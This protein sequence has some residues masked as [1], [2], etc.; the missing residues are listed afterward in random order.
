MLKVENEL[1]KDGD[2]APKE[3]FG[4]IIIVNDLMLKLNAK[5]NIYNN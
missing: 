3:N 1:E 4:I 5:K 2:K